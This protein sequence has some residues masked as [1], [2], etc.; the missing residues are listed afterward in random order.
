[1]AV[2]AGWT[3]TPGA[4]GPTERPGIVA[5]SEGPSPPIIKVPPSGS[6]PPSSYPNTGSKCLQVTTALNAGPETMSQLAMFASDVVIGTFDGLG[7]AQWKTPD[8]Q[9]PADVQDSQSSFSDRSR[10][11]RRQRFEAQCPLW[12]APGSRAA[13]LVATFST[14]TTSLTSSRGTYTFFLVPEWN[15]KHARS[16]DPWVLWAWPTSVD[17]TVTSPTEGD[18][19]T[20][21][22][23]KTLADNRATGLPTPT[24]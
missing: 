5:A 4:V 12:Q 13:T 9:R 10:S 22:L 15:A 14:S 17:G 1:M 20:A 8:G 21:A 2:V 24:P 19:S 23:S 16:T 18:V 3:R 6:V 11:L 7:G